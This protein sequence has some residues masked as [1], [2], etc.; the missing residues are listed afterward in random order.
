MEGWPIRVSETQTG[1]LKTM[2]R[3]PKRKPVHRIPKP[4]SVD[5]VD[6]GLWQSLSTHSLTGHLQPKSLKRRSWCEPVGEA[7]D[8]VAALQAAAGAGCSDSMGQKNMLL[9][10]KLRRLD[11]L[12]IDNREFMA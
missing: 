4:D 11:Q 12:G 6:S 5:S 7:N 2:P 10:L 1:E 9:F 3:N 8:V